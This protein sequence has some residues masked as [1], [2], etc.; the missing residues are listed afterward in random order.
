MTKI[1]FLRHADTQKDPNINAALWGLSEKGQLQAEEVSKNTVMDEVDVI[2]ISEEK[3]TLLT[4][5]PIAK[6]LSKEMHSLPFFDEV[7]RG[8]KFLTKEEFEAEKVK[9]LTDLSFNAFGG[10]SGLEALSR[11]K[12][13][14][15]EVTKQN[16]GKTILIVTHGTVLNIYFADLLNAYDKLSERWAKTTFCAFGIVEDGI[17]VKDIV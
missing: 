17:M 1:I 16:E 15:L 2:Y 11:F 5:E 14:V 10:E 3:K 4:G 6:K 8:D 9:Q 12:Q 13:G 7:K